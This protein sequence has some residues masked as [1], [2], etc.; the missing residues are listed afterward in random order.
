MTA[1]IAFLL[2]FSASIARTQTSSLN[3]SHD[4]T[5]LNIASGNMVP[6]QPQLDS[7]P[8][9]EAAVAY[10]QSKG[11]GTITADP[12]AY[13]FLSGHPSSSMHLSFSNI[14]YLNIARIGDG[15][16]LPIHP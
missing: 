10:A 3:L 4:L 7:R 5:A 6:N 2:I 16:G 8:L 1:R 9:L 14:G 12:G 15:C 11:I 13:Y